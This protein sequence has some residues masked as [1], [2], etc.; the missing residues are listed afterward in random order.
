MRGGPTS[1]GLQSAGDSVRHAQRRHEMGEA[2][3]LFREA[4][5]EK[6]PLARQGDRAMGHLERK[7][8]RGI[9]ILSGRRAE[10]GLCAERRQKGLEP[11]AAV[12][13]QGEPQAP[14]VRA[15][16]EREALAVVDRVDVAQ[17]KLE[18]QGAQGARLE[19]GR[20]EA[21]EGLDDL[22]GGD[23]GLPVGGADEVSKNDRL[24]PRVVR[25]PQMDVGD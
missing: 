14:E 9:V 20:G 23:A 3:R 24:R 13:E 7:L 15:R 5:S 10:G 21:R 2:D 12:V 8:R 18:R 11:L 19:D 17:G 16:L 22:L 6:P 25:L 4:A 1:V